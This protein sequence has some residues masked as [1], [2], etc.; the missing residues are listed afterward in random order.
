MVI[1]ENQKFLCA[2]ISFKSE[3]DM[4]KGGE[5][6]TKLTPDAKA[7]FKNNLGVEVSTTEEACENE[8][9]KKYIE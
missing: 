8:K 1:G 9:I 4:A 3:V 7:F 2:L 6:L 5:P